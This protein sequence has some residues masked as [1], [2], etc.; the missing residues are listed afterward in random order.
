[1]HYLTQAT[2]VS[3]LVLWFAL[4]V[5]ERGLVFSIH[6]IF[7]FTLLSLAIIT[8]IL[9]LVSFSTY[10]FTGHK[11]CGMLILLLAFVQCALGIVEI[12][13]LW[14]WWVSYALILLFW[15]AVFCYRF[16]GYFTSRFTGYFACWFTNDSTSHS[17]Q[18]SN[19][20]STFIHQQ[21]S[22]YLV[23]YSWSSLHNA[24]S[25]NQQLI[26]SQGQVY[27]ISPWMH[28]TFFLIQIIPVERES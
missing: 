5:Y 12:G 6:S 26:V 27:D 4:L 2:G 9:G 20:H 10:V 24:I 18:Y 15:T 11:F 1:M 17:M 25:Q 8:V 3:L 28:G 14:V 22:P 7:G 19:K 21:Y 23:H 16:T 13:G